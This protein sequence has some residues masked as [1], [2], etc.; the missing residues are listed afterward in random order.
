MMVN[1]WYIPKRGHP[2]K[3]S[4]VVKISDLILS[5]NSSDPEALTNDLS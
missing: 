1:F 5:S 4:D 2:T 3:I